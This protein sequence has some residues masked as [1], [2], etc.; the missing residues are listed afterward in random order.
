[1]SI[2]QGASTRVAGKPVDVHEKELIEPTLKVLGFYF[3]KIKAPD[4]TQGEPDYRLLT[5]GNGNKT[6]G[7]ALAYPWGRYLDGKDYTRDSVTQEE[8]PGATVV[9]LLEKGDAQWAVVTNG[10]IWRLYSGKAHSRSTNYYEIDVEELLSQHGPH[11][12]GPGEAF[13]YFWLLFRRQSFDPE[14]TVRDGKE[15]AASFLDELLG[16]SVEYAKKL[17]ERLKERVFEEIFPHIADGFIAYIKE[18]D[19]TDADLSQEALDSVFQGTL[20]LL[21]RILFL[22]Y[23]EARDLLPAK[24]V[25][26]YYEVSLKK[27][28]KEIA[29]SAGEIQDEAEA[30]LKKSYAAK[31]YEL[32]ERLL[33]LFGIIDHGDGKLNVPFY[34]GGLFLSDPSEDDQTPEAVNARFLKTV[35]IGDRY[36]AR[37]LDLLSRDM[38][39][40]KMSSNS[41]ITNHSVFDSSG[42]SMK[43]SWNSSLGSPPRRW[44]S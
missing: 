31:S 25:R 23:A 14:V 33:S 1:M 26:G 15:I 9:S 24:E 19:G 43:G 39:D 13:R 2:Y 7:V 38:D 41:S 20:T 42:P 6:V 27:L 10:R 3:K 18:R 34:N 16:D 36:L 22:L 40:K 30:K 44:R 37:A 28:K 8:N 35:K 4:R 29:E 11:A 32:C 5:P 21:Y 12:G 17:G